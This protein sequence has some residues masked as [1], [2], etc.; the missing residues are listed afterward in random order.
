M[1]FWVPYCFGFH[2]VSFDCF[3]SFC[4]VYPMIVFVFLSFDGFLGCMAMIFIVF[5]EFYRFFE[6]FLKDFHSCSLPC[7]AIIREHW[8]F[9]AL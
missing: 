5:Y 1:L 8:P 2:L 6:C 9:E 3:Y 4:I 7:K